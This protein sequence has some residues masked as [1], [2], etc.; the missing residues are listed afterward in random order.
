VKAALISTVLSIGAQSGSAGDER[1]SARAIRDGASDT[2]SRTGRQIV[3]RELAR[4]PTL[5]ITPGYR[6]RVLV[7]Q[8]VDVST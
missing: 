1:D 6:L 3:D 8:D 5:S 2:I 7:T 4:K